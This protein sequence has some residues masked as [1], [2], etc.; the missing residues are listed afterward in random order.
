M[1]YVPG[2]STTSNLII[3]IAAA[4]LL[5]IGLGY[6]K[7]TL[8]VKSTLVVSAFALALLSVLIWAYL[9]YSELEAW[10][11]EQLQFTCAD[12]KLENPEIIEPTASDYRQLYYN[13]DQWLNQEATPPPNSLLLKYTKNNHE[14]PPIA[15]VFQVGQ[16]AYVLFR[17][18]GTE[19]ELEVDL[20]M[21][22]VDVESLGRMH[23]GF[24]GLYAKLSEPILENLATKNYQNLVIFGHFFRR[25]DGKYPES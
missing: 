13:M 4:V 3:S 12:C 16:T 17:G 15:G 18:T 20:D 19:A 9:K 2:L 14:E 10:I 7:T 24:A 25:C 11:F 8:S 1:A 23:K 22:Q 21:D 5:M 6:V